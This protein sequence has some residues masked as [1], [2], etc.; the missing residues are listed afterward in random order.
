MG[1][2]VSLIAKNF[3]SR[4]SAFALDA[5]NTNAVVTAATTKIFLNNF[6]FMLIT[7]NIWDLQFLIRLNNVRIGPDHA[8]VGLMYHGV[9]HRITVVL[10][11]DL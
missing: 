7:S 1:F 11:S 9:L 10:L 2:G 3:A 8:Q 4:T 5:P 6:S